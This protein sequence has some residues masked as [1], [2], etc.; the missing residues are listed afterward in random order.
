MRKTKKELKRYVDEI[1]EFARQLFP[2][3][4]VRVKPPY[5]TEDADIVVELPEDWR[6]GIAK[7]KRLIRKRTW[8][9][10]LDKGYDI[11]V[12]VEKP[13]RTKADMDSKMKAKTSVTR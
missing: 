11:V 7:Q 10:L 12:F 1:C 4:N 9:I 2:R 13:N 8:D 6:G 3:A 5:E